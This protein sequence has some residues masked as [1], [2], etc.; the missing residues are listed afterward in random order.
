MQTALETPGLVSLA[1][2]FVDQQTLPVEPRGRSIAGLLAEPE[3]GRRA[4]Q[5]GTTRAT[6]RSALG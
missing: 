5:Y 1:A 2:G 3:E 4:L 6:W